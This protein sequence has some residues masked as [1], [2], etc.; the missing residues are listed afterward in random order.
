MAI[1]DTD[2]ELRQRYE[3]ELD[4]S[5]FV[6]N[7]TDIRILKAAGVGQ[8]ELFIAAADAEEVNLVAS[9]FAKHLGARRCVV[10][11]E[12]ADELSVYRSEYE[13]LFGADLLLSPQ[14]LATIRVVNLVLGYDTQEID[15]F[16]HGQVQLRTIAIQEGSAITQRS[17]RKAKLP[18]GTR[19]VG[20]LDQGH[21]LSIPD[22]EQM[23]A[24]GGRAIVLCSSDRADRVERL[25][26]CAK[27]SDRVVVV[28]GGGLMGRAVARELTGHVKHL[29]ILERNRDQAGLV[30]EEFPRA[31]VLCGDVTNVA[32]LRSHRVPEADTFVAALGH[33]EANLM[34]AL[35]AQEL[36]AGQVIAMVRR[37]ETSELWRKAGSFRAVSPRF[38]AAER[39]REYIENGYR[40]NLTSLARG[41]L[42]LLQRE[43]SEDS[44][45]INT[46]LGDLA[47]PQG[48][49][50]GAIQRGERAWIPVGS[51]R[52]LL[53]DELLLFVHESKLPEA[54]RLFPESVATT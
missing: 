11:L 28:A 47:A 8:A 50:V 37:S 33:D 10:R 4:V 53:G 49:I 27:Q 31:D 3:E 38:L 15:F 34:A 21:E 20:Y 36:G 44:P 13:Q 35:V 25:F 24:A 19:V 39:I 42:R 1:V 40:A 22:P 26:A 12:D 43:V 45:A 51:D 46:A 41:A 14:H 54:D 18:P 7:G 48:L 6:G 32:F 52:L 17:L 16:A 5:F 2:P 29:M 30:A 23:P 9:A